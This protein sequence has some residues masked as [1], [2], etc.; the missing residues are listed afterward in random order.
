MVPAT[1]SYYG[2]HDG[3][4]NFDQIELDTWTTLESSETDL[5]GLYNM[6]DANAYNGGAFVSLNSNVA[7][8][9]GSGNDIASF[10]MGDIY[11]FPTFSTLCGLGLSIYNGDSLTVSSIAY[12]GTPMPIVMVTDITM[13]RNFFKQFT[14]TWNEDPADL[15]SHIW[16]PSIYGNYYHIYYANRGYDQGAPWVD[17]DVDDVTS[18]GPEHVTIYEPFEGSYTFAVY[19]FSGYETI[20]T[21]GARVSVVDSEGQGQVF[22]VPNTSSGSNYWWHV[23]SV[24]GTTG[25]IT[26]INV[27]SQN[28][29]ISFDSQAPGTEKTYSNDQ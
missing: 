8:A 2:Y 13:S 1:V 3:I 26:P 14:L 23:C 10:M 18:Y 21:S 29:P 24:D 17:L 9:V 15:D 7:T 25:D 20:T 16:T 5:E 28:P 22:N 4:E 12:D 27:I 6:V 19:H 11:D